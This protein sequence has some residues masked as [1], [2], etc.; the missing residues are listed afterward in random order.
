MQ[1]AL[2]EQSK[3]PNGNDTGFADFIGA[4]DTKDVEN[5]KKMVELEVIETKLNKQLSEMTETV[6]AL[7]S[8]K[9]TLSTAIEELTYDNSSLKEQLEEFVKHKSDDV[10]KI[11]LTMSEPHNFY[12]VTQLKNFQILRNFCSQKTKDLNLSQNC[13]EYWKKKN[14]ELCDKYE[15]LALN[16]S[17][18]S[19]ASQSFQ[20]YSTVN[21]HYVNKFLTLM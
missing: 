9:N 16:Y 3:A 14:T 11:Q 13:N 21:F 5:Q 19:N 15:L 4:L 10:S 7:Q 18:L 2:S 6:Y 17:E 20:D 8:E 1:N 12:N